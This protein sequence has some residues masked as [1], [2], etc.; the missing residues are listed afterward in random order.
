MACRSLHLSYSPSRVQAGCP[1]A[2]VRAIM[3]AILRAN[4]CSSVVFTV[5]LVR[6]LRWDSSHSSSEVAYESQ[7]ASPNAVIHDVWLVR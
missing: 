5:L 6:G 3:C 7:P 4:R 2:C 1:A